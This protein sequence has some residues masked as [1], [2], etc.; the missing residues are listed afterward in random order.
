V[1]LRFNATGE[2][3]MPKLN[4]VNSISQP[5]QHAPICADALATG[6]RQAPTGIEWTRLIQTHIKKVSCSAEHGQSSFPECQALYH[7]L[8]E[9][10]QDV[11]S[12]GQV[13]EYPPQAR[14]GN[15]HEPS[16]WETKE[17][18]IA[19]WFLRREQTYQPVWSTVSESVLRYHSMAEGYGLSFI[20]HDV[21]KMIEIEEYENADEVTWVNLTAVS[22]IEIAENVQSQ[23]PLEQNTG[24]AEEKLGDDWLLEFLRTGGYK[25]VEKEIA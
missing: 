4:P 5:G 24:V 19:H 14:A 9:K 11:L 8:V 16:H 7:S 21:K 20:G 10:H 2:Y 15:E 1:L 22:D 25:T 12:G 17:R 6:T 3:H 23:L 13:E 18:A